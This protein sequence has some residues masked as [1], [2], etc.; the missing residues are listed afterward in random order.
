MPAAKI[1]FH[2][3][4]EN[5]VVAGKAF[6]VKDRLK[7]VGARWNPAASV[8]TIKADV[9]T[10][11]LL[12]ELNA[13]ADAAIKAE[14]DVEKKAEQEKREKAA[15]L[16]AFRKTPEG[17][18]DLWA[19]I[20]KMTGPERAAY[21]FICCDKCEVLDWARQH[22]WCEACGQDYGSHKECF[23]VRGMLRTG[24]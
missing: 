11:D 2:P 8:W 22:T 6:Y 16:A 18:A 13:L 15:A 4:A 19:K 17:K 24:D 1:S 21:S 7:K 20:Q 5:V 3:N 23:F 14:K 9:A 12:A 10:Q